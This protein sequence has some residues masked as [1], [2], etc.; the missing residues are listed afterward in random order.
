MLVLNR[1]L[2]GKMARIQAWRDNYDRW[3]R[4]WADASVQSSGHMRHG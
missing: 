3:P 1:D 2:R 4:E